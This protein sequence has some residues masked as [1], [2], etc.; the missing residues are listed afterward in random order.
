[1]IRAILGGRVHT[2]NV[3]IHNFMDAEQVAGAGNDPV[4]QCRLDACVFKGAVKRNGQWE[5]VPM[6]A[7]NQKSWGEVYEERLNDDSLRS[8]R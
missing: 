8:G 6:C 5:A 2:L 1:M 4:T 3:G 7:M